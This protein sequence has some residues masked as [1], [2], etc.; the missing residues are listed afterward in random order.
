MSTDPRRR[1]AALLAGLVALTGCGAPA[2]VEGPAP[3]GTAVASSGPVGSVAAS[4]ALRTPVGI[5]PVVAG[6]ADPPRDITQVCW[7]GVSPQ[8][9]VGT[10]IVLGHSTRRKATLG[11]LEKWVPARRDGEL[12]TFAGAT[13]RVVGEPEAATKGQLPGWV[14]DTGGRR[15]LAV[16]TCDLESKYKRGD[17]GVLHAEDNIVLRLEPVT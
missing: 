11:Y 15:A 3:S 4:V 10:T 2:P 5:C 13:Y 7:L 17:D 16:V 1:L 9:A 12:V 6:V 8:G 14:F